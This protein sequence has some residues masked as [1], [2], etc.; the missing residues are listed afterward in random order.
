M[1]CQPSRFLAEIPPCLLDAGMPLRE[2]VA[3]EGRGGV[4]PIVPPQPVRRSVPDLFSDPSYETEL[5]DKVWSAPS[6]SESPLDEGSVSTNVGDWVNH[7]SWGRGVIQAKTGSGGDAKLTVRFQG[8]TK[9]IVLRYA[10][11]TP[12]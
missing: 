2:I 7:P 12:G 11:L 4:T 10:R 1:A 8:A 9:K 6:D 3:P 5:E